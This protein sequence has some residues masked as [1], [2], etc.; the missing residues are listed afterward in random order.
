MQLAPET[1]FNLYTKEFEGKFP[2]LACSEAALAQGQNCFQLGKHHRC[3]QNETASESSAA[4]A[5]TRYHT[6]YNRC[7]VGQILVLCFPMHV[8]LSNDLH[9]ACSDA[10][11]VA[12]PTQLQLGT[13]GQLV[14]H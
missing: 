4:M 11:C 7:V 5:W 2:Y 12:W 1:R 8:R 9:N 3:V 10:I 6:K 13:A 14:Q